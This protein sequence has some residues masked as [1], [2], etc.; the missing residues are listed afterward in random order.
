MLCLLSFICYSLSAMLYLHELEI[1]NQE[2]KLTIASV[3]HVAVDG[4][5]EHSPVC[6]QCKQSACGPVGLRATFAWKCLMVENNLILDDIS[7][8]LAC[9]G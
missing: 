1:T 9:E 8:T 2:M 3:E 6:F 4:H 5:D 7:F